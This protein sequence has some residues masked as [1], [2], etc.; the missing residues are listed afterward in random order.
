MLR[1]TTHIA[2]IAWF[3]MVTLGFNL[4][5]HYCQNQLQKVAVWV[6]PSSCHEDSGM[7]PSCHKTE[8]PHCQHNTPEEAN[9]CCNNTSQFV[10][11]DTDLVMPIIQTA[12]VPIFDAIF[13]ALP[14]FINV[15][16]T[17]PP[18]FTNYLLY[19]PPLVFEDISLLGQVFLC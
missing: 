5:K 14:T 18:F 2:F 4:H 10:Q 3:L 16:L 17:T 6:Q 9:N 15:S 11:L 19:K 1:Q 7:R 8:K 12:V 13:F